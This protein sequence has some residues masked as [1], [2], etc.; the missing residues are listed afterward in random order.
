MYAVPL[1]LKVSS[2][3]RACV[4]YDIEF[5]RCNAKPYE[6]ASHSVLHNVGH[7]KLSRRGL[8]TIYGSRGEKDPFA[9]R[10][11]D[12]YRI[13]DNSLHPQP[14]PDGGRSLPLDSIVADGNEP[15]V[16]PLRSTYFESTHSA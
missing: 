11:K 10:W 13:A 3:E 16:A 2:E 8:R 1:M 7:R 5:R 12:N 4:L 9:K 14:A 6:T 15:A